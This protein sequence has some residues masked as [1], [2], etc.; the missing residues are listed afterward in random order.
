MNQAKMFVD[1]LIPWLRLYTVT[2][3]T[4]PHSLGQKF[5]KE[6]IT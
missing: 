2:R 4:E 3:S 5:I 1:D 6:N